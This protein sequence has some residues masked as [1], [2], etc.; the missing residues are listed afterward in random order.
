MAN[1]IT[2]HSDMDQWNGFKRLAKNKRFVKQFNQQQMFWTG[3]SAWL[4]MSIDKAKFAR[5]IVVGRMAEIAQN[6]L[7]GQC[8]GGHS[9]KNGTKAVLGRLAEFRQRYIMCS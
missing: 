9:C 5:S 3:L 4:G 8:T 6:N 2:G 7:K 1:V